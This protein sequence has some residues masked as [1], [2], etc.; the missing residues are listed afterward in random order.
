MVVEFVFATLAIFCLW[1]QISFRPPGTTDPTAMAQWAMGYG[2]Q[3]RH[4]RALP[5]YFPPVRRLFD[6]KRGPVYRLYGFDAEGG[7][8]VIDAELRRRAPAGLEILKR[9]RVRR[10]LDTARHARLTGRFES[11]ASG[12]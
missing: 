7:R 10:G 9:R 1:V 5:F 6:H 11:E 3:A 2:F 4:I 8:W 12:A